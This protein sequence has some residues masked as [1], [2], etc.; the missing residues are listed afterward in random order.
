MGVNRKYGGIVWGTLSL[1]IVFVGSFCLKV[2]GLSVLQLRAF[3]LLIAFTVTL[4]GNVLPVIQVSMLI[5]CLIPVLGISTDLSMVFGGF[6]NSVVFFILASFGIA[7]A[8]S[9]VPLTKRL[10]RKM[11]CTNQSNSKSIL[12]AL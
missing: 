11:L 5:L 7:S 9:K 2:D 4:V 10:L 3:A 6:S 12:L 8:F 1:V